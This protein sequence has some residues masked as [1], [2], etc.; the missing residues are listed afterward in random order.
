MSQKL[1]KTMSG[2]MALLLLLMAL[3]PLGLQAAAVGFNDI[4]SAAMDIIQQNEGAYGSVTKDDNGALS[5]GWIQWHGNRALSLL[6]T[7]VAA[8][9]T[10]ARNIL[11]NA[12]YNEITTTSSSGWTT[13]ILN[14]DEASRISTLLQTAEGKKAQDDL[15]FSDISTYISRTMGYGVTSPSALVYFADLENQCGA[16]G[17]RRV[18]NAA[19]ALVG[20]NY[21]AITLDVAHRAAMADS[22]AGKYQVRRNKVYNYALLLGWD[23][24]SITDGCEIWKVEA[25]TT[26]NVRSGPGT[27]FPT[28]G[29]VSGGTSLF[30]TQKVRVN[31]STW[32]ECNLGWV[33][34][35]YCNYVSG[36]VPARVYFDADGGSFGSANAST[37]FTHYNEIRQA[38]ALVVYTPLYGSSTGTNIHG[39]EA[40]VDVNGKIISVTG[41][42]HGNMSIPKHGFVVSGNGNMSDWLYNNIRVGDYI[43]MDPATKTIRIYRS[44]EAYLQDGK[45]VM[46]GNNVG[47][48]PTPVKSGYVFDGWYTTKTGGTRVNADTKYTER[49]CTTLYARWREYQNCTITYNTNG[50]ALNGA[51]QQN[52]NGVDIGRGENYLVVFTKGNTTGTNVYGSEAIVE[53]DGRVSAVTPYGVG[54]SKIPAGGFVLSGHNN[55]SFW[56]TN[57]IRVGN[58][59]TY[60][61]NKKTV[62]ICDSAETYAIFKK[63]IREGSAIGVLPSA[64]RE[65]YTF[66]GWYTADGAKATEN[67]IMPVGGLTLTAAWE[68]IQATL[69]LDPGAGSLAKIPK[70]QRT[71]TSVNTGRPEN[72]MIIYTPA[73]GQST[74]TNIHG[75]EYVIDQSGKVIQAPGYGVG[76]TRIPAGCQVLSG[77]GD[78]AWWMQANI[79]LG[80]YVIIDMQTLSV[81]VYTPT[82]YHKTNTIRVNHGERIGALPVPTLT[83][84]EFAGWYTADDVLITSE[85]ISNFSGKVTLYARYSDPFYHLSF[86]GGSGTG[87]PGSINFRKGESV[88]IPSTVPNGGCYAFLGWAT[89]AGG[90][91]AYRPGDTY[92]GGSAVLYAVYAKDH[93]FT[94]TCTAV[95]TELDKNGDCIYTYT[96]GVCGYVGTFVRPAGQALTET[97]IYET[98]N[99]DYLTAYISFGKTVS[100]SGFAYVLQYDPGQ[101]SFYSYSSDI[102]G[103]QV[104]Q[105][106]AD[107]VGYIRLQCTSLPAESYIKVFFTGASGGDPNHYMRVAQT[108][109]TMAD[110]VPGAFRLAE[111]TTVIGSSVLG[112]VNGDG[113]TTM[114]DFILLSRAVA[115]NAVPRYPD[116]NGDGILSSADLVVLKYIL[117]G[118]ITA[119]YQIA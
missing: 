2:V 49:V 97:S 94:K 39:T 111:H 116:I 115:G 51:Q 21:S 55:M 34:L 85:T 75:I 101:L 88:I 106:E 40:A 47:T 73:N 18:I 22:V 86:D 117:S 79:A 108:E 65:H 38:H 70:A 78:S 27:S 8:N 104:E 37:R 33:H 69:T 11:G 29:S 71:A 102:P 59:I 24:S 90:T 3:L 41:Y 13:R 35:G 61:A 53:A 95:Y 43:S 77:H 58:Y 52:I 92:A 83:D 7:I 84:M 14:S 28:Q 9:T 20:G 103:V 68:R 31:G 48:L 60:D 25:G 91:V 12:L 107:G 5:V 100:L 15:A 76:S 50:G 36:S 62:T 89:K 19:A 63:Q 82:E 23:T 112:D 56:M 32:G 17:A 26:L 99:G 16:G 42:G 81:T 98:V 57:S 6:Q 67:T 114:T 72:A 87:A 74:G 44:Y 109:G 105:Y 46:P 66:T 93:G 113:E 80:D 54:N 10:Q 1:R 119:V 4:V 45:S 64:S 96:C 30:I 110:G 118:Q